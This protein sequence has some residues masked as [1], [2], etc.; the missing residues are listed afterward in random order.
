MENY[1]VKLARYLLFKSIIDEKEILSYDINI[2]I[3]NIIDINK[4]YGTEEMKKYRETIDVHSENRDNLT[5]NAV[6]ILFSKYDISENEIIEYNLKFLEL[7]N[8]HDRRDIFLRLLGRMGESGDFPGFMTEETFSFSPVKIIAYFYKFCEENK[9]VDLLLKGFL[10]SYQN[11]YCV[12]NQGKLQNICVSVLQ[13]RL[14][15]CNIDE[16]F[17]YKERKTPLETYNKI[18]DFIDYILAKTTNANE[19]FKEVIEVLKPDIKVIKV[20][21]LYSEGKN[22][23]EINPS[24][25]IASSLEGCFDCTEYIRLIEQIN[26]LNNLQEEFF[27]ELPA[28]E[29]QNTEIYVCEKKIGFYDDDF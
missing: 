20:L 7:I 23:F 8:N 2:P 9:C 13:G 27:P 28:L 17:E 18:K 10:N 21:C 14:D 3:E 19:F 16:C 22:G 11:Q 4:I 6:N 29:R 24:F 12:C 5:K 26:N 1:Y 25:S 15:G